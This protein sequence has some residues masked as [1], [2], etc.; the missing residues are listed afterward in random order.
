M[1]RAMVERCRRVVGVLDSR[2]W[3]KVAAYTFAKLEQIDTLITDNDSA[4]ALVRR[5]HEQHVEVIL[6]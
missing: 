3:G 6:V 5:I 4:D 2:K 1:K